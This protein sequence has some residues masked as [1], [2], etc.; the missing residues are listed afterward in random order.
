MSS[1][2]RLLNTLKKN[3]K[4]NWSYDIRCV[5]KPLLKKANHGLC[6]LFFRP[7]DCITW[8]QYCWVN[9]YT[10]YL[11]IL[12]ISFV[13]Q[14]FLLVLKTTDLCFESVGGLNDISLNLVKRVTVQFSVKLFQICWMLCKTNITSQNWK[15]VCTCNI[16]IK[17]TCKIV[18]FHARSSSIINADWK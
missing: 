12:W 9:I 11:W 7:I 17:H 14:S 4:E 13:K 10:K 1:K 3:G 15:H 2:N 18:K 8:L 16:I 6:V 5:S